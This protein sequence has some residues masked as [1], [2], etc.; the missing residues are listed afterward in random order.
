[1]EYQTTM[2][3]NNPQPHTTEDNKSINYMIPFPDNI[4]TGKNL[5]LEVN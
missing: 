2:D 3:M 4:E 1:M 5:L